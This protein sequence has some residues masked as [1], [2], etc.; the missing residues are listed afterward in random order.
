MA[1]V[2]VETC[3]INWNVYSNILMSNCFSSFSS[4]HVYHSY[5][6]IKITLIPSLFKTNGGAVYLGTSTMTVKAIKTKQKHR[7][8]IWRYKDVTCKLDNMIYSWKICFQA[9]QRKDILVL[10]NWKI[11]NQKRTVLARKWTNC[12]KIRTLCEGAKF[13]L[14]FLTR[15]AF[16]HDR[17]GWGFLLQ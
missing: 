1:F 6:A 10:A 3:L 2:N 13:Y 7:L 5:D 9:L 15:L 4:L 11:V 12:S 17:N 14:H 16:H 8:W